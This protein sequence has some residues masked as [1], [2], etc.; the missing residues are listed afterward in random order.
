MD[1]ITQDTFN[2]AGGVGS[3]LG[4]GG[5]KTK[6]NAA[7]ICLQGNADMVIANGENPAVLYDIVDGKTGG[8]T[9]FFAE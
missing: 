3:A 1:C 2:L 6:L 4:T 9:R 7:K 8:Y 5:M